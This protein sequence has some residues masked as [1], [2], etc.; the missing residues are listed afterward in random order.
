MWSNN[1][2]SERL[3]RQT[4]TT[5]RQKVM[6]PDE[7]MAAFEQEEKE[8]EL[9]LK[10]RRSSLAKLKKKEEERAEKLAERQNSARISRSNSVHSFADS[11][12][13]FS[14]S[15]KL[16]SRG[17]TPRD[18]GR[19]DSARGASAASKKSTKQNQLSAVPGK[20]A[21]APS[22]AKPKTKPTPASH[23]TYG[24]PSVVR[25]NGVLYPRKNSSASPA[26]RSTSTQSALLSTNNTTGTPQPR[27]KSP[28]PQIKMFNKALT[29]PPSSK[30]PMKSNG[31]SSTVKKQ[32][33]A[34]PPRYLQGVTSGGW[35]HKESPNNNGGSPYS[36]TG[37]AASPQDV[38]TTLRSLQKDRGSLKT[39]GDELRRALNM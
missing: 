9:G 21:Q 29:T 23:Q 1:W 31:S 35:H 33:S 3:E 8:K 37:S 24:K 28:V 2:N 16:S 12:E 6:Y 14:F 38:K 4:V 10:R 5:G 22:S 30:N 25:N 17:A 18:G 26:S 13:N 20:A 7:Y 36:A 32:P 11:T 34:S 39:R 19:K 27:N 15:G